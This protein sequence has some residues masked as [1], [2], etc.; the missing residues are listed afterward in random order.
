MGLALRMLPLLAPCVPGSGVY[1]EAPISAFKCR[2]D[3]RTVSL[4]LQ[5]ERGSKLLAARGRL[6]GTLATQSN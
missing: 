3:S 6:Q 4:S 5:A 1:A 2:S